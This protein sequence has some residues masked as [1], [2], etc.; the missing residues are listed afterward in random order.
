MLVLVVGVRVPIRARVS[1]CVSLVAHHAMR[2][3]VPRD[4]YR[5]RGATGSAASRAAFRLN[6]AFMSC[7][8]VANKRCDRGGNDWVSYPYCLPSL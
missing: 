6:W 1:Q 2:A 7:L 5:G 8:P 4:R 3:A